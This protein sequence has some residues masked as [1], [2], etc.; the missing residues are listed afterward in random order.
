MTQNLS[1]SKRPRRFYIA[2]AIGTIV[3]A[4]VGAAIKGE[5]FSLTSLI[6]TAVGLG[7]GIAIHSTFIAALPDRDSP[8]ARRQNSGSS[9][10]E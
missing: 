4:A 5:I 6:G 1:L 8:S 2:L 10:F 7:L 9:E 3:G